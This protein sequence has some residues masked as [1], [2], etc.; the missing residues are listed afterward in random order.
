[1]NNLLVIVEADYNDGDYVTEVTETTTEE[2]EKF[3][4]LAKKI[5]AT[6]GHPWAT[7]EDPEHPI[8]VYSEFGKDLVREFRDH[9][10]PN[11]E[12]GVHSINSIT[13]Y[14]ITGSEVL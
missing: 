2:F 5:S 13:I 8:A 4:P 11:Y 1:M 14:S 3:L 6:P 10:V 9:F 12:Y 7:Q